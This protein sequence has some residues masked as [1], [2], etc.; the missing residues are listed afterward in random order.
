MN[1]IYGRP[2][3]ASVLGKSA[4]IQMTLENP[5]QGRLGRASRG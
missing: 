2:F 1:V 3:A 5:I 4:Y